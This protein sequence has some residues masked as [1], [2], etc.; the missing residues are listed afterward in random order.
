[1]LERALRSAAVVCSL[2]V[3]LGWAL[4]AIAET[5]QASEMTARETAGLQASRRVTPSPDQERDRERAHGK[6]REAV[7]D[8]NDVLLAPFAFV[9]DGS[10][11]EWARRTAPALIALLLYGFGLGYVARLTR[12]GS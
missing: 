5:R 9:T 7:D 4:F 11:S 10:D 6:V 3:V 8:A 12:T 1:M 2:L